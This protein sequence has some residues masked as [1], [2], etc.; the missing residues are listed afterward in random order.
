MLNV[1]N[2]ILLSQKPIK[3]KEYLWNIYNFINPTCIIFVKDITQKTLLANENVGLKTNRG[4]NVGLKTN[5]YSHQ[6]CFSCEFMRC[7]KLNCLKN[8]DNMFSTQDVIIFYSEKTD[9]VKNN[10]FIQYLINTQIL[11]QEQYNLSTNF[12]CVNQNQL[13]IQNSENTILSKCRRFIILNSFKIELKPIRKRILLSPKEYENIPEDIKSLI[14]YE[15]EL[16]GNQLCYFDRKIIRN[17]TEAEKEN[18]Y[19]FLNQYSYEFGVYPYYDFVSNKTLYVLKYKRNNKTPLVRIHSYRQSD[20]II[21]LRSWSNYSKWKKSLDFI[22]K[23]GHGYVILTPGDGKGYGLPAYF[24]NENKTMSH[25]GLNSDNRDYEGAIALL[26]D[27]CFEKKIS[28][29]YST[30]KEKITPLLEKYHFQIQKWY[31]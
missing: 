10:D 21:P 16:S 27:I 31:K 29:L 4:N 5:I 26:N 24:I 13:F 15:Q 9:D 28:I 17:S 2:P 7:N 8:L 1:L 14:Y 25:I 23:N 20:S 11:N 18:I 12:D 19:N 30:E 22:I 6:S 3:Y